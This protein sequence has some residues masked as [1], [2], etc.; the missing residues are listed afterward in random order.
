M[1]RQTLPTSATDYSRSQRR[2]IQAALAA[3]DL[4]WARMRRGNDFDLAWSR[5][6]VRVNRILRR[7]QTRLV[8]QALAYTP[9]VLEDTGQLESMLPLADID[10][11]GL[12]G[13]TG[14]G[15]P[16]E[17]VTSYA[18]VRAKQAVETGAD[19][20]TALERAGDWLSLTS[21]TALSDTGRATEALGMY[22]H[23]T[24]FYVRMLTPPSCGRCV[25]L[26]GRRY[27][28]NQGF[29]RHPECD[30]RHIPASEAV[31]GDLTVDPRA[32]FDSLDE[33]GQVKLAG[34]RANAQAVRDG[35][36]IGQVVNAY[37]RGSGLSLA[38]SPLVRKYGLKYTEAGST[39]RSWSTQQ[40]VGL[41]V[42]DAVRSNR[43]KPRLMPESIYSADLTRDQRLQMLRENGWILAPAARRTGR[44]ALDAQVRK[45]RADRA[46]TRRRLRREEALDAAAARADTPS[47]D[48]LRAVVAARRARRQATSSTPR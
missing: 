10:P 32:Y 30:C 44:A 46:A 11:Q 47:M 45:R 23:E 19:P 39:D 5:I 27:R 43:V 25:I 35:A 6:S 26:A 22:A 40:Q 12:V 42:R 20:L 1:L 48:E 38:Q 2:E 29:R 16:V 36:D 21:L 33:A 41:G 28:L 9:N 34:S 8:D 18:P 14:A 4:E 17:Y 7:A 13:M 31:A 37:R 15:M 24:D 3:I